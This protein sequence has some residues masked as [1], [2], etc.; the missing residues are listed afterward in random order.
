M[1]DDIEDLKAEIEHV[2]KLIRK[3]N[4]ALRVLELNNAG[5]GP[6]V[7]PYVAIEITNIQNNITQSNQRLSDA[8]SRLEQLT[9]QRAFSLEQEYIEKLNKAIIDIQS[10]NTDNLRNL[11]QDLQEKGLLKVAE[12][13]KIEIDHMVSHIQERREVQ[14]AQLEQEMLELRQSNLTQIDNEMNVLKREKIAQIDQEMLIIKQDKLKQIDKE[15]YDFRENEIKKIDKEILE[16]KQKMIENLNYQLNITHNYQDNAIEGHNLTSSDSY[17]FHAV[18]DFANYNDNEDINYLFHEINESISGDN[19]KKVILSDLIQLYNSIYQIIYK[20]LKVN[21]YVQKPD[22]LSKLINDVL[23]EVVK[24]SKRN[25]KYWRA[26]DK[27]FEF[28]KDTDNQYSN[29]IERYET[30]LSRGQNTEFVSYRNGNAKQWKGDYIESLVEYSRVNYKNP[31]YRNIA[32]MNVGLVFSYVGFYSEAIV[33]YMLYSPK[34]IGVFYNLIVV[35]HRWKGLELSKEI[36]EKYLHI[37]SIDLSTN[38]YVK[39]YGIAGLYALLGN[40]NMALTFLK[41]SVNYENTVR[42]WAYHDIAWI[43]FRNE[44]RF[45]NII[46]G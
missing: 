32:I 38:N 34:D 35:I 26:L 41:K 23:N 5:F 17:N 27:T 43:D 10:Y 15:V 21:F 1:L 33:T 36:I 25:N 3:H 14:I 9:E 30:M 46:G 24:N 45:M 37:L 40:K 12:A 8:I 6:Y 22:E 13:I 44:P 42:L 2:K 28:F 39:L 19:Q 29:E 18:V 16:T 11:V 4:E 20:D 7:P 31:K